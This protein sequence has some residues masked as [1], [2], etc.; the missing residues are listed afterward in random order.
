[1]CNSIQPTRA[2]QTVAL[3]RDVRYI[4]R[5][6]QREKTREDDGS[7][8]LAEKSGM[9]VVLNREG[10]Y[11]CDIFHELCNN[12]NHI[13]C[14]T[15]HTRVEKSPIRDLCAELTSTM[16]QSRCCSR[17]LLHGQYIRTYS[18][19]IFQVREQ[20]EY[21]VPSMS[22]TGLWYSTGVQ[23]VVHCSTTQQI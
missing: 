8:R 18:L 7:T 2:M 3:F 17:R 12:S 14:R 19:N 1:M 23:L 6:V 16:K 9:S 20:T 13:L 11:R 21:L 10:L 4:A 22:Q 15:Y 5:L